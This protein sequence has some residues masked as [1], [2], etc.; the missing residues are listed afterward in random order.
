L[1]NISC[2]V[3]LSWGS[4]KEAICTKIVDIFFYYKIK[5]TLIKG[6]S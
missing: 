6:Y 3:G 4:L 2:N 1:D 5:K